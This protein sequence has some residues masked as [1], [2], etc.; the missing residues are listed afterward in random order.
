MLQSKQNAT[1]ETEAN[2]VSQQHYLAKRYSW[3]TATITEP[4]PE[5]IASK[6]HTQVGLRVHRIVITHCEIF[7]SH[8]D[9][10]HNHSFSIASLVPYSARTVSARNL[11]ASH[12]S[13]EAL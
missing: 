3:I 13:S 7:G 4:E 10:F 5:I 1:V 12:C 2:A 9:V 8:V 11:A 6:K